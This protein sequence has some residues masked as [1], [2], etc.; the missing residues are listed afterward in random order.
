MTPAYAP[1]TGL[2]RG[3]IMAL[4]PPGHTPGPQDGVTECEVALATTIYRI[5]GAVFRAIGEL[6][7]TKKPWPDNVRKARNALLVA[8]NYSFQ[9][10]KNVPQEI[11]QAIPKGPSA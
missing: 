6:E 2:T 7:K 5:R 4:S 8:Q 11:R 3:V 9:E 1:A 10:W